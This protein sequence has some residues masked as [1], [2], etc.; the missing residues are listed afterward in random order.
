MIS[1]LQSTF[2]RHYKWLFLLLLAVVIVSFVLTITP[3]GSGLTGP[4]RSVASRD[5]F[6]YNLESAKDMSAL[7]Q[8]AHL[9]SWINTGNRVSQQVQL[10]QVALQRTAIL[11]AADR[12]K[13]PAPNEDQ[14]KQYIQ[15]KRVFRGPDGRF[16]ADSYTQFIDLI[17]AEPGVSTD[18]VAR[19]LAEDYRIDKVNEMLLGPGYVIPFEAKWQV[20]KQQ[21]VWSVETATR[22]IDDFHPEIETTDEAL[23]A[24]Y[25]TSSAQYR[26][27]EKISGQ[28]L[29]FD[30]DSFADGVASPGENELESYFDS[31]RSRFENETAD[32]DLSEDSTAAAPIAFIEVRDRVL[33]AWK[34]DAARRLAEEASVRFTVTLYQDS[35]KL[36]SPEYVSLL[37]STNAEVLPIEPISQTDVPDTAEVPATIL[38]SLFSLD[39][40]RYFS[41]VLKT[42]TGAAVL[43][44]G[45]TIE[46]RIPPFDDIRSQVLADFLAEERKRLF[47]EKGAKLKSLIEAALEEGVTFAESA[48]GNGLVVESFDNFTTDGPPETFNRSLFAQSDLLEAGQLSP[49]VVLGSEGKFVYLKDKKVTEYDESAP[50]VTE[51]ISQLEYFSSMFAGQSLLSELVTRELKKSEQPL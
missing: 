8:V 22:S 33:T 7:V 34:Q 17:E 37:A 1:W 5:Y 21:T 51:K 45:R 49:M 24:Y 15:T 40:D 42:G 13:L 14:L 16:S 41:D 26:E 29:A 48:E 19:S 44:D 9:S 10:Q 46:S 12:L 23:K 36:A 30:A 43:I 47:A 38:N 27:G 31:N 4:S 39:A 25:Q 32:A 35:V 6:G 3:A 20:E 28:M 18:L 2:Q 50:A 11:A